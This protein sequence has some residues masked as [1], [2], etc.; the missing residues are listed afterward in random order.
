MAIQSGNDDDTIDKDRSYSPAS[1]QEQRRA[2]EDPR[3]SSTL[4][5]P[6]V[7]SGS[8]KSLPG[9]GGPDDVGEIDVDEEA[10]RESIARRSAN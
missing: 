5:D 1:E 2:Q 3:S 10:I 6:E 4:D 9:T 7:D 8:V